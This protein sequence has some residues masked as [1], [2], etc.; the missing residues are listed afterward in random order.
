MRTIKTFEQFSAN[1]VTCDNCGWDWRLEEGGDAP[2]KC[3]ECGHDNS[4]E[5]I[6]DN[7]SENK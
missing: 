2:F 4:P 1:K 3:H 7:L 6:D 5:D